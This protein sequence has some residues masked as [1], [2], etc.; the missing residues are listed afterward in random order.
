MT[1]VVFTETHRFLV[2]IYRRAARFLRF[3]RKLILLP[4]RLAHSS[5]LVERGEEVR[6]R[7]QTPVRPE[8]GSA[9]VWWCQRQKR[10]VYHFRRP[11]ICTY[12]LSE[13]RKSFVLPSHPHLRVVPSLSF[14]GI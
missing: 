6:V 14:F 4:H 2:L 5:E 1:F 12:I 7:A 9:G 10:F 3:P 11:A 8:R 13:R